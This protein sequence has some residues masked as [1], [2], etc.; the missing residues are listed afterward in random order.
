MA[1]GL[2][3]LLFCI[4]L[5]VAL[6]IVRLLWWLLSQIVQGL[7]RA[8]SFTQ[9]WEKQRP[10]RERQLQWME[11]HRLTRWYARLYRRFMPA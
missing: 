6:F 2:A 7:R 9:V 8:P 11:G 1:A 5:G 4:V 10:M 3:I